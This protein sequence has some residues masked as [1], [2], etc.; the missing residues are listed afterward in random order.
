M[1]QKIAPIAPSTL[2]GLSE[3][4]VVGHYEDHYGSAVRTLN[5]VRR[6]LAALD[7]DTPANRLGRKSTRSWERG[8]IQIF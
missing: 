8:H 4:M 5:E 7:A 1:P 3:R 2:S 6:V